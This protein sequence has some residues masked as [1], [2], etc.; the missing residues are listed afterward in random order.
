MTAGLETGDPFR[1]L[2]HHAVTVLADAG[3]VTER[4]LT[5][6]QRI[7]TETPHGPEAVGLMAPR[8][9]RS[10]RSG[11]SNLDVDSSFG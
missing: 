11:R 2:H 6:S 3:A 4:N 9:R 1:P 10:S 7:G 5:W 8:V